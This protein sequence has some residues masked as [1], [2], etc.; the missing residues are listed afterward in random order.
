M[1]HGEQRGGADSGRNQPDRAVTGFQDERAAGSG[2]LN[3]SADF[4]VLVDEAA[5]HP[6]WLEFHADPVISQTGG[7]GQRITADDGRCRAVR[8]EPQG[9]ELPRGGRRQW[10]T[11]SR[12]S[13]T[14]ITVLLS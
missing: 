13:R 10:L 2:K 6:M 8:G 5:E 9:N 11:L 3:R 1:Q 14:E 4:E 7:S 12:A